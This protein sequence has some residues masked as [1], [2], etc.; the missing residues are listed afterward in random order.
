MRVPATKTPVC[1]DRETSL[2]PRT[3]LGTR[4]EKRH[5]RSR[6]VQARGRS[7]TRQAWTTVA[8]G[9]RRSLQGLEDLRRVSRVIA[10]PCDGGVQDETAGVVRVRARYLAG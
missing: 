9:A 1:C 5:T 6:E 3:V 10:P 4:Q 8:L 2:W 7:S